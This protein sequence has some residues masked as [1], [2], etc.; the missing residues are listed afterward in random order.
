MSGPED[1]TRRSFLGSAAAAAASVPVAGAA[2]SL[3]GCATASGSNG[4]ARK[5]RR[6]VIPENS[7]PGDKHWWI[8]NQGA[9]DAIMGYAGQVSVLPGEPIDLYVST[10][11]REFSVKAFRMG[12]YGGDRARL[13]WESG[14]VNGHR[15]RAATRLRP[16]N[17]VRTHWGRS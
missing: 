1:S 16:T 13:V 2:V 8:K 3:A 10:T 6:T 5:P 4:L 11:S 7:L 14:A 9:H 12:W 17:T 15:Q